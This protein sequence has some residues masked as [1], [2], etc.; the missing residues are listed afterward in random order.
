MSFTNVVFI[1]SWVA[2]FVEVVVSVVCEWG[3]AVVGSDSG[4][5]VVVVWRLQS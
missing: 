4:G 3:L 5:V 1:S 2:S